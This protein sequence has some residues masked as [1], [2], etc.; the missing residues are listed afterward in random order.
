MWL[1]LN[2][3]PFFFYKA[4]RR[5]SLP[6]LQST[7]FISSM[8]FSPSFLIPHGVTCHFPPS[9]PSFFST[10]YTHTLNKHGIHTLTGSFCGK[11]ESLSLVVAQECYE[12]LLDPTLPALRR[13]RNEKEEKSRDLLCSYGFI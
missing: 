7:F 3:A 9:S 6:F 5:P 2:N 4:F 8:T 1:Y 13:K 11:L 10:Q 12:C